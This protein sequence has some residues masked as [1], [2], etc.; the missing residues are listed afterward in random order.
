MSIKDYE[1]KEQLG[2]GAQGVVFRAKR[3]ADGGMVAVKQV[4]LNNM[5]KKDQAGAAHEVKILSK[6]NHPFVI[7]YLESFQDASTLNIVTELAEGGSLYDLL[8]KTGRTRS[9]LSEKQVWKYFLQ[10]TVGLHHIH[11]CKILHRDVK[12][13]NLFLTKHDDIK[14]G[15]LGV[16]RVLEN[17]S[18]MARTM[19][20][21][22]YY[23]SPELC[24]GKPYNE[25]SDVWSLGCVL[26]E[27][28][29]LR[30]P[31]DA[32]NQGA[33]ILKIITGKYPPIPSSFSSGLRGLLDACLERN[34]SKRPDTAGL[35][36]LSSVIQQASALSVPL[37]EPPQLS[38]GRPIPTST[39]PGPPKRSGRP[40]QAGTAPAAPKPPMLH[41][42]SGGL[43]PK[44][45]SR[46]PKRMSGRLVKGRAGLLAGRA[47]EDRS[48]KVGRDNW[49]RPAGLPSKVVEEDPF[50]VVGGGAP[51]LED[52]G[53][54]QPRP[55]TTAVVP[56]KVPGTLRREVRAREERERG[57]VMVPKPVRTSST[58][59][60]EEAPQGVE[61][62]VV[63]GARP[64]ERA[65]GLRGAEERGALPR[66]IV[67]RRRPGVP[68]VNG[69]SA[70][71]RP[72]PRCITPG[73]APKLK[74]IR[75]KPTTPGLGGA[76]P[77]SGSPKPHP[78]FFP[79]QQPP[80]TAPKPTRTSKARPTVD[81]LAR[82]EV[83]KL[84]DKPAPKEKKKKKVVKKKS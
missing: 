42:G 22:P 26:Y 12:T 27:L 64:V 70:H 54:P 19:V 40:L 13:M 10:T 39:F 71:Q 36:R 14:V 7:R 18:D 76:S 15:D 69:S 44:D 83:E 79:A 4:F 68:R 60:E 2:K 17:T 11:T 55:R 32:S 49:V 45:P 43:S 65:A 67:G 78:L 31:F 53:A 30:H 8:K 75:L 29:T 73:E 84:P 50:A 24:E 62:V 72:P 41:A 56:S 25:K 34:T 51:V 35:F 61:A 47:S 80:A 6:L 77:A 46:D 57:G 33:L 82:Q 59:R 16:A 28:C 74:E 1:L 21:T 38:V 58:G 9:S 81:D 48:E 23:L 3:K 66:E 52:R 20:G 5:S 37:P 63:G